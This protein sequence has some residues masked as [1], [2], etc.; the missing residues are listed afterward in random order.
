M[1]IVEY[2]VEQTKEMVELFND[3]VRK[4]NKKDYKRKQIRAWAPKKYDINFWADKFMNSNTIV[5][6]D[7]DKIVGFTNFENNGYIDCFYTHYQFQGKHIG[8]VMLEHITNYLISINVDAIYAHV[9]I[10]AKGFYLKNDFIII[11]ENVVMIDKVVL[12]NYI[13]KKDIKLIS[14]LKKCNCKINTKL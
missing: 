1:K 4:I 5:V 12:N 10:S 13:M 11:K 3:T 9:S 6:M 7:N 14:N 2:K 8:S